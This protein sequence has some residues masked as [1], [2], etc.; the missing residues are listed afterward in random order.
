VESVVDRADG[1]L[2]ESKTAGRNR[3]TLAA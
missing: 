2:Y 3:V 1:L